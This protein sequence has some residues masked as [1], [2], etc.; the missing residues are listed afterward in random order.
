[1][2]L[3]L[4][5]CPVEEEVKCFTPHYYREHWKFLTLLSNSELSLREN[6]MGRNRVG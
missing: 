1:M 6:L 2:K 5:I 3:L 4:Y